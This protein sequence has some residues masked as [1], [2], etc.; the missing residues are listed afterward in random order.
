MQ[1]ALASSLGVTR[2]LSAPEVEA[3]WNRVLTLTG[4]AGNVPGEIYFGLWNFYASRGQLAKARALGQERL[5]HGTANNDI[6]S[7]FLG[8]YT[9]AAA[10]LFTGNL[11]RAR[12]GFEKLLAMYPR[13]LPATQSNSY[14]MGI[15]TQSLLGDTLWHLGLADAAARCWTRRPSAAR[16]SRRSP[17]RS[18]S[19]NAW[20]CRARCA[21]YDTTR[22][23]AK[24]LIALSEQALL[25]VLDDPLHHLAR[26]G[27]HRAGLA[28]GRSRQRLQKAAA[29]VATNQKAHGSNLQCSRFSPG[30][31]RAC[32][33][34]GRT[35]LARQLLDRAL[36]LTA[37]ERYWESELRR[38]EG[39]VL[40]AEGAPA[41]DVKRC[42]TKGLAIARQQ[43]ARTFEQRLTSALALL[44]SPGPAS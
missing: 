43:G 6:P 10:D 3:V 4:Q 20:P 32:L 21:T 18:P 44:D 13:D 23:V 28:A 11:Q 2:G 22:Q 7:L 17:T 40:K 35:P 14:D 24:E 42:F 15:V 33:E 34:H 1:S 16:S 39:L 5:D 37:E 27:Q 31:R 29:A 12:E 19:C 26:G 38:L 8:L 25:S 41:E 9:T 36:L 30:S